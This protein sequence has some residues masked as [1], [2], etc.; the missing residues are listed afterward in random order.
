MAHLKQQIYVY[1]ILKLF[2]LMECNQPRIDNYKLA[3]VVT[4]TA[5]NRPE[6]NKC[7]TVTEYIECH[8]ISFLWL[9]QT[10]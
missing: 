9:N 1:Y 6:T 3:T 2:V 10:V 4:L 5:T 7:V 8:R